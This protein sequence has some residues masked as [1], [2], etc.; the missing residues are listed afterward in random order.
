MEMNEKIF[1]NNRCFSSCT[2]NKVDKFSSIV[3]II[4]EKDTTEKEL[5]EIFNE[6]GE[7]EMSL[8]QESGMSKDQFDRY[9]KLVNCKD[10]LK[11]K[12]KI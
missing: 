7:I 11:H 1:S 2:Y 8:V 3:S 4:L 6:V 12:F 5:K 10:F 9:E